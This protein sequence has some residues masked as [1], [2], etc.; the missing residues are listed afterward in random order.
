M[1]L[2]R[3]RGFLAA[4]AITLILALYFVLIANQAFLFLGSD[5]LAAKGI[6]A[7]LLFLPLLGAWYLVHEF[8]LGTSVQQMADTLD[9]EGRLPIHDGETKPSGKLTRE[10]AEAVFEVASR[11][12]EDA[13][14][15]WSAWFHLAYAY[16]AAGERSQARKTLRHAADLYRAERKAS[17]TDA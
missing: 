1:K 4:V 11:Q 8:R 9:R 12:V 3:N 16:E 14:E 10:S 6:G 13:P 2:M 7:A 5:E 15:D 17:R